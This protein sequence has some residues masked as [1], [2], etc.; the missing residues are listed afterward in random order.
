M[1]GYSLLQ[2]GSSKQAVEVFEWAGAAF[3]LSANLQDSLAEAYEKSGQNAKSLEACR[4]ALKLAEK[5]TT[6]TASIRDRIS[7]LESNRK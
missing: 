3:P 4:R 2:S 6:L 1:M 7:R 5:D